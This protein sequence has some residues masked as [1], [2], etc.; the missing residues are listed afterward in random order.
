MLRRSDEIVSSHPLINKK[1][2]SM[3][4]KFWKWQIATKILLDSSSNKILFQVIDNPEIKIILADTY[5]ETFLCHLD[6][7]EDMVYLLHVMS[8][9]D[10][11]VDVGAN[12]GIYTL[13]ASGVRGAKSICFE[14][15][16][17]TYEYLMD[18]LYLNRLTSK[19]KA[20]NYGVSDQDSEL[21]FTAYTSRR[22]FGN[23]VVK[24]GDELDEDTPTI[25]VK[26]KKLDEI[27][28]G[29]CPSVLKIDAEGYETPVLS[30]AEGLLSNPTL[31][32]VILE[33]IGS[34]SL[35]GFNEKDIMETMSSHNFVPY[36]YEPFSRQLKRLDDQ[37]QKSHGSRNT[38]FIRDVDR[39]KEKIAQS[40]Y[41]TINGV[42]F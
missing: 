20:F 18:N 13:L 9:E 1:K 24:E 31:H 19:V 10:L 27:L 38:I 37:N 28:E 6:E 32:T 39:V 23:R 35:Y 8:E 42:D 3:L 22:S 15:V 29:E 7:W 30:G 4:L 34:G 14:P 40:S 17:W 21:R 2:T 16:P 5:W 25:T 36:T 11:L 33:L 41:L 12:L 26:V